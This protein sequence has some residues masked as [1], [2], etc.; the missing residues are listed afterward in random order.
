MSD[1]EVKSYIM[2]FKAIHPHVEP[3]ELQAFPEADDGEG[4]VM[5]NAVKLY[6]KPRSLPDVP[7]NET[8]ME[9][10]N[11][12]NRFVMPSKSQNRKETND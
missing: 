10:L 3:N 11:R 6:E 1:A 7:E 9:V 4:I 5:F 2:Q 12:Y 8:S